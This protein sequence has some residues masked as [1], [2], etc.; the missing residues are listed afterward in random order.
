MRDKVSKEKKLT[1]DAI[2]RKIFFSAKMA[3]QKEKKELDKV[4]LQNQE[5]FF[6]RLRREDAVRQTKKRK[7]TLQKRERATQRAA[8]ENGACLLDLKNID[9]YGKIDEANAQKILAQ[10]NVKEDIAKK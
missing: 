4:G 9:D 3:Q 1:D 6:E 5:T 8:F 2:N 10:L 7:E